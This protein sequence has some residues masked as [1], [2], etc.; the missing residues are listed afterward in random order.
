M[1]ANAMALWPSGKAKRHE[2]MRLKRHEFESR[3]GRNHS[4]QANSQLSCPS[5]C[6]SVNEY[7]NKIRGNQP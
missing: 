5:S 2:S 1:I 6:R 4:P 3:T 7:S